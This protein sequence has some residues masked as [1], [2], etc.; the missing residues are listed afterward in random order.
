[1]VKE[2]VSCQRADQLLRIFLT[3]SEDLLRHRVANPAMHP[4]PK[5]NAEV[6]E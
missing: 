1:M 2:T 5:R 4:D 6:R 3:L